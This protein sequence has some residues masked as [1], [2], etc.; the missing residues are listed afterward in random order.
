[1]LP[2]MNCI[3][4]LSRM[5]GIKIDG[6]KVDSSSRQ[7]IVLRRIAGSWKIIHEHASFLWQWT[8]VGS[9]LRI[10]CRSSGVRPQKGFGFHAAKVRR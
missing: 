4:G 9:L 6:T 1:M 2:P 5:T 8:E 3:E 7:T 10:F